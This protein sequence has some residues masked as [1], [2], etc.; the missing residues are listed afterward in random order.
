MFLEYCFT[1][2]S[3]NESLRVY[4]ESVEGQSDS[5]LSFPIAN[6][7]L[8]GIAKY[9]NYLSGVYI[10]FMSEYQSKRMKEIISYFDTLLAV[11]M[12]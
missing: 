9:Q 2:F 1:Y 3:P 5:L 10:H 6:Y 4:V 12:S 8:S 11:K 7:T